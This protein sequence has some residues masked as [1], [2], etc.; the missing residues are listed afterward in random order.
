MAEQQS[1]DGVKAVVFDTFGTI[2]DWRGSITR[3][4]EALAKEKGIELSLI[5]I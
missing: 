2:T 4:G 3:Q 1:L 5:H